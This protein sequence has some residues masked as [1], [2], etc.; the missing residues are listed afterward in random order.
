MVKY[1][2]DFIEMEEGIPKPRTTGLTFIR[3]PG[4]GVREQR[5]YLEGSA[6]FLDYAK[7]RNV[8]PR[9]FPETLIKEKIDLYNEFDVGVMSGGM[10]FQF[11]WLQRKLDEYF[12]YI[13]EIGY[14]A[15]EIN[16]GLTDI[17]RDDILSSIAR[18]NE[19]DLKSIFEWGRK[20]PTRDLDLDEAWDELSDVLEVGVDFIVFEQGELEWAID[21]DAGQKSNDPLVEL[22]NRVGKE[23]VVFEVN[24]EPHIDWVIATFGSD[25]NLGPNLGHNQVLWIEPMRR[26]LGRATSY[27]ALDKWTVRGNS[28]DDLRK[29]KE[30]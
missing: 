9:M 17:P 14:A 23:K 5:I 22:V 21:R 10:F 18:M 12:N 20:Y 27:R 6:A 1:A 8:T 13:A 2:Y 19:L 4:M 15:A 28:T 26:G 30:P 11:C 24:K 25:A 29:R 7:F 16:F 3:D